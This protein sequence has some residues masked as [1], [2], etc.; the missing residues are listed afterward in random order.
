MTNAW[1]GLR[2][3]L[4][5]FL[6]GQPHDAP[7]SFLSTLTDED[8]RNGA[9]VRFTRLR[10]LLFYSEYSGIPTRSGIR[11]R[12]GVR[13]PSLP[14]CRGGSMTRGMLESPVLRPAVG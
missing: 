13:I 3:P 1:N 6:F 4:S 7:A 10:S 11:T 12:S 5:S 9:T 14:P 2:P 8:R